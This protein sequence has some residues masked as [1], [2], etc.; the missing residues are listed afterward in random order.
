MADLV[1]T[2]LYGR[3]GVKFGRYVTQLLVDAFGVSVMDDVTVTS[4]DE[5]KVLLEVGPHHTVMHTK[6]EKTFCGIVTEMATKRNITGTYRA[7]VIYDAHLL[8]PACQHTMRRY[9]EDYNRTVR[10]ILVTTRPDSIIKPLHSRCKPM[11]IAL[12][13]D[14]V[15]KWTKW[16]KYV[17][18]AVTLY[19]EKKSAGRIM[20]VRNTVDVLESSGVTP[21][22]VLKEFV[23][24]LLKRVSEH[25]K[26]PIIKLA[27]ETDAR[28][29]S[30]C[31]ASFHVGVFIVNAAC[32]VR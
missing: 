10:F 29:A 28:M 6:D 18:D 5:F 7:V 9:M 25:S 30:G 11:R 26:P 15:E 4:H 17:Q 27:A 23:K 1:H 31:R 14:H 12:S 20:L 24:C 2:L 8:S 19:L 22:R 32:Y 21:D 16:H 13:D 3:H